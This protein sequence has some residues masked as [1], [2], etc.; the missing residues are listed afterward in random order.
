MMGIV[1]PFK[2]PLS[3]QFETENNVISYIPNVIFGWTASRYIIYTKDAG[4][5]QK[6]F[7]NAEMAIQWID[8]N[9]L[10]NGIICKQAP[11]SDWED[12]VERTGCVAF[13]NVLYALS[14]KGLSDW[15]IFLGNAEKSDYYLNRYNQFMVKFRSYFWDKEKMLFVISQAMIS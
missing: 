6:Y 8:K 2:E 10:E 15:A 3:P 14:L 13:T 9:T 7:I 5:A 12:S 11:F 1:L 4:F